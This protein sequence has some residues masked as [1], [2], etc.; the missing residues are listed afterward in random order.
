[1]LTLPSLSVGYT[2]SHRGMLAA[3]ALDESCAVVVAHYQNDPTFDDDGNNRRSFLDD[4][5]AAVPAACHVIVYDKSPTPCSFMPRAGIAS[6]Q[7][8]PNLGREQHTYVHYVRQNYADLPAWLVLVTSD[9]TRHGR[10][11]HLVSM[12]DATVLDPALSRERRSAGEGFACSTRCGEQQPG[13]PCDNSLDHAIGCKMP[14]YENVATTPATPQGLG[15][16]LS[17]HVR[18]HGPVT[19]PSRLCNL[20]TCHYGI[21]VSRLG[22]GL[23]PMK[24]H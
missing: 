3:A 13:R 24:T 18:P 14:F 20:R 6:C 12:L 15:Q 17:A 10:A 5:Q 7:A 1:M 2:T 19:L 21:A 11:K 8:L 9:L 23:H 16:W 4:V 22:L